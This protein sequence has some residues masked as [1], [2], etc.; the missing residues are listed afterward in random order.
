MA[1]LTLDTDHDRRFLLDP[2]LDWTAGE[3]IPTHEDFGIDILAAETARWDR[4]DARG[5]FI[6]AKGRGDFCATFALELPPGGRTSPQKHLFEEVVY[7]LEGHGSTSIEAADGR[8]HSFEWGPKSLFALPLNAR[9]Q[10][11]NASGRARALLASTHDL[12]VVMNLFH[13]ADFIFANDFAFNERIGPERHHAG[14]GDFT[15]IRPGSHLWETN[16]VPDLTNFELK[17]WEARGAGSSNIAFVLADGTMHTH[18]SEIP[19]GRY[20][21]GH[22]H[23]DGMHVFAVTGAGYSLFW[24]EGEQTFHSVPWR[25]GVMYAP[26]HLMFHQHF[27][28]APQPARYIAVGIGSRRYPFIRMRREAVLGSEVNVRE[29]GMQID[30]AEQDARIH[31]IWLEEMAKAGVP[32]DMGRYIDESG[33]TPKG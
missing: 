15:S 28:T 9:Y 12:P 10:H 6:H 26:P 22:R 14:G 16:F 31:A 1:Q 23:G 30:Y 13:N 4:F 8:R 24:H 2:Y 32:S 20:K 33:A 19:A 27:N 21:K 11:F 5:A 25:H 7:V 3:G 17:A 18:M 29:G